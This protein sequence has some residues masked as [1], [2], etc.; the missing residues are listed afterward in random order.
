MSKRQVPHFAQTPHQKQD[1]VVVNGKHSLRRR[2]AGG[3]ICQGETRG[4][5]GHAQASHL[6][7]WYLNFLICRAGEGGDGHTK[8]PLKFPA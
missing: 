7:S 1:S 5:A 8:P 6:T 3:Q 2:T 4:L